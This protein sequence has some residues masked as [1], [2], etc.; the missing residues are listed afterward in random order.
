MPKQVFACL[1]RVIVFPGTPLKVLS[2]RWQVNSDTFLKK[3]DLDNFNK[4]IEQRSL[5]KPIAHLT[6]RKFFWKS[7]F[8]VNNNTLI[9]RPDTELIIESVLKLTKQKLLILN[10]TP[11]LKVNIWT[12]Y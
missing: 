6:N 3:N 4:L 7:E 2:T 8:F 12:F 9:P 5:G 1:Y 10:I 11:L